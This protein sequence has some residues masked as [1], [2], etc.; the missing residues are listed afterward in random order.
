MCNSKPF[1][2]GSKMILTEKEIGPWL[3][4]EMEKEHAKLH[5]KETYCSQT[6]IGKWGVISIKTLPFHL[7]SQLPTSTQI[8][9]SGSFPAGGGIRKDEYCNYKRWSKKTGEKDRQRKVKVCSVEMVFR[10]FLASSTVRL[11]KEVGIRGHVPLK[12]TGS[13]ANLTHVEGFPNPLRASA[14]VYW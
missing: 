5:L 2:V 14:V 6:E 4:W 9:C 8:W 7:K 3:T 1:M 13:A 10:G 11:L 12:E